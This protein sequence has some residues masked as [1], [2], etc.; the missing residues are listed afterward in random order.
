MLL[1]FYSGLDVIQIPSMNI[2]LSLA[3]TLVACS[4]F[5]A[6]CPADSRL[7][8]SIIISSPFTCAL[9]PGAILDFLGIFEISSRK[10]IH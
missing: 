8:D 5:E 10:R 6:V 7:Q 9:T 4:M 1:S 3:F 2:L